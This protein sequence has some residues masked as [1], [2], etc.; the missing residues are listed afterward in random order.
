MNK[1]I[2]I[3]FFS[4]ILFGILG[5]A[6]TQQSPSGH[7]SLSLTFESKNQIRNE[8]EKIPLLQRSYNELKKEA[9]NA[10][11]EGIDVPIPKDP[12]GGYTHN[13]HKEN[14]LSMYAAGNVFQLSDDTVYA[15]YVRE[16]LLKYAEMYPGLPEHPVKKSYATGKLFWQQLNEAV[17]MVYTSQAYDCIY[18]YLSSEE[19]SLIEK[20]LLFPYAD[21]LSVENIKVF[22][23]IHNHGVWACAAVGMCGL[24][25]DNDELVDRALYG[26]PV[27]G[28]Q[29]DAGFLEQLDKLFSPEGYYTEG[30][31]Y[32]RYAL[33]PY[34]VFAQALNNSKPELGIF[35]YRNNILEKAVQTNLQLTNIDGTFF[36]FNDAMKGMSFFAPELINAVDIVYANGSRD[37]RLLSVAEMQGKVILSASGYEVANDI[38]KDRTKE[39]VW[40]SKAFSDGPD[41]NKGG[42]T[43]LRSGENGVGSALLFKYA[44]HGLSHGHFDRL[45]INYFH[46]GTEILTDYGSARFVNVVQKEGGR[47]L[48]ENDTWAKQTIAHNTVTVNE[49]SHFDGD[50]DEAEKYYPELFYF[51]ASDS[52]FQVVS[53]KEK[54]AVDN[55]E[56]QRIIISVNNQEILGKTVLLDVYNMVSTEKNQYDLPWYYSGQF[57]STNANYT[58]NKTNQ[59]ALGDKN[60]YQ[61]LWLEADGNAPQGLS[62]TFLENYKFYTIYSETSDNSEILFARIGA[63]DPDFNLRREP[64]MIIRE[65]NTGNH[66]FVSV[67]EPHGG[68]DPNIEATYSPV[69]VIK[70]VKNISNDP[71]YVVVEIS[72]K[73]NDQLLVAIALND[74]DPD[75]SHSVSI[76]NEK[77]NWKGFIKYWEK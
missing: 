48:P 22:N 73:N 72:T 25:T 41:G 40:E 37:K 53:A 13:Q 10:I 51:N 74:N 38:D 20:N 42:I 32:Q 71:E 5:V 68:T 44:S 62:F 58:A 52:D 46:N 29:V 55:V 63:H 61:H 16:M 49:Q 43:I 18:D 27:A 69:G 50:M 47:Y 60:G 26:V 24:A 65:K 12:A 17:W 56:M 1:H 23:R 30:P 59:D 57:I 8:I 9:D 15:A 66:T 67:V 54:N 3:I 6:C 70:S 36:T 75:S 39:F 14:Y 33:L 45:G 77:I 19:R 64:C 31:Y 2:F 11:E 34:V 35:E 21:F 7:P 4:I 76:E 28:E